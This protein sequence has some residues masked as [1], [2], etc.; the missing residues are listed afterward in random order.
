MASAPAGLVGKTTPPGQFAVG[1]QGQAVTETFVRP[2]RG[3]GGTGERPVPSGKVSLHRRSSGQAEAEVVVPVRRR[4]PGAVRRA[5]V[6]G[7]V[8]PAAA[9]PPPPRLPGWSAGS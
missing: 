2:H 5:A 8:V 7:I 6:L 9:P 1:Y 4:V 3:R